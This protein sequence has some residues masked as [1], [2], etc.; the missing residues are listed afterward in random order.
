MRLLLDTH[1][2]LWMT[3]DDKRLSSQAR[4][5]M[6]DASVICVSSA[7]IWE[8]AV[9]FRLGK[10]RVDP[11]DAIREM[12]VC[13]FEELP[14]RNSHAVGVSRL[15]LLHND[16]FDRLLIA[17]AMAEPLRFLTADPL[18]KEYSELVIQV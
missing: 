11:E 1:I 15:P 2:F 5:T 3:A 13:G 10:I 7:T 9:K 6:R 17:Q 16:P 12:E 4:R 18:L 14:V 8:I